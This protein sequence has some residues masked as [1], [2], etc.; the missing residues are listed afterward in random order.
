ME[1]IIDVVPAWMCIRQRLW[2]ASD[3]T[4]AAG[5]HGKELRTFGTMTHELEA[6]REW[7]AANG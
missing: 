7:L 6:L 2:R 4:R 1:R 3:S 5:G